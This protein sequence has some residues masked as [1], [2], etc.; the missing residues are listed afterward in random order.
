MNKDFTE[1]PSPEDPPSRHVESLPERSCQ[2]TGSLE[3]LGVGSVSPPRWMQAHLTE[4]LSCLNDFTRLQ[5][6]RFHPEP[7]RRRWLGSGGPTPTEDGTLDFVQ[8]LG[9]FMLEH[10]RFWLL[11]IVAI[12]VLFVGLLVMTQ[13]SAVAPFVYAVW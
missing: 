8:E 10:K 6:L 3:Q 7:V 5:S 2:F 12:L 9:A 1:S 13:G 4:C 11:P